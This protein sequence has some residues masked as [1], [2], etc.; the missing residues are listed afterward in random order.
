MDAQCSRAP[1][2]EA[3]STGDLDERFRGASARRTC[4]AGERTRFIVRHGPKR[5]TVRFTGEHSA[6]CLDEVRMARVLLSISHRP[7]IPVGVQPDGGIPFRQRCAHRAIQCRHRSGVDRARRASRATEGRGPLAGVRSPSKTTSTSPACRPRRPAPL[8]LRT[9]SHRRVVRA[10]RC[11]RIV[12]GKTNL[13]Q[14]ACGLNGTR[15]PYGAVPNA[16]I[17]ATCRGGSSSGSAYV[18]ATGQVDFA[19]GTDTAGSGRVPAGLNNIVGLKPSQGPAQRARRGAGRRRAGLRVDLRAHVGDAAQVL[20]AARATT[21]TTRTRARSTLARRAVAAALP[22][23][24]AATAGVLR[25]RRCAE[26]RSTKRVAQLRGAGRHA[27]ADRLRAAARGREPAV[28]QRAGGRALRR[29]PRSF[30]DAQRGRRDRAG[31][32]HHRRA[33]AAT[34]PPTC[35]R[36]RRGCAR[37]G[38]QAA[39]MWD[40]HRRAA[41]ADRAH[42]LHASRRCRPT[43]SR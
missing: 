32:Q 27:R 4:T 22:L 35:S 1:R 40:A 14:F 26:R 29:G 33:A 24:R 10:A 3:R 17:R 34:A 12:V 39:P 19:L 6:H 41:G 30:F 7:R 21:R 13:D 38:Q 2:P 15:S 36:R 43:R 8:R 25:R 11:R 18:V 9:G 5:I 16:S 37:C 31:A 23:R 28:R 42:A 20:A